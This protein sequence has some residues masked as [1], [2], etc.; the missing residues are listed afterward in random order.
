MGLGKTIQMISLIMADREA[1]Q[2]KQ[3]ASGAS[4]ILAPLSVMSNWSQQIERHVKPEHA[5]RV[6]TYHGGKR[7]KLDLKTIVN[8]D[9]VITTYETMMAEFFSSTKAV[10]R[11]DGLFSVT[12]RRLIMDE[13]HTI[14]NPRTKK[15]AAACSLLAQSRWVLTGTP[16]INTLKDLFSLVKFLRLSGGLDKYEI[17]NAALIRPI[18]QGSEQGGQLLQTL[19]RDICLRR[20][21]DMRFIDLKLPELSEYV[22]RI[23]FLEHE[24]EKYKSL[25]AEAQG[26]LVKYRAQQATVGVNAAKEYRFL[27]EILL[28]MRQVCNHWKLCGEG[29]I[30]A[31]SAMGDQVML[32]LTPEN[33]RLLQEMLQ[34]TIDA[35]DDC[36]V[37]M[38]SMSNDPVI[39]VCTHAYCYPCIERVIETQHK[40]PMCRSELK[41]VDQLVRPAAEAN[42][43]LDIDENESSSKIETLLQILGASRN[44]DPT[45]KTVIFSQWTTFID[46]VQVQLAKHGFKFVRIDGSM[47][48]HA[49]DASVAALENDPE[50]TILLASLAVCSVGLN[51][52]AANQA[53]LADTW[54]APAIEQQA[55]DRIH[56][57]GQK[58]E[59][60]VFRLVMNGSIEEEVLKIQEEKMKL[61]TLA[62]AEKAGG[63]KGKKGTTSTIAQIER[64]LGGGK[65]ATAAQQET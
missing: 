49:R 16:I 8:Y 4:L 44:K 59:T 54:W 47:P 43:Q 50:C 3:G 1:S 42:T 21:K 48:P 61:M 28:R 6:L 62:F 14:R 32:D 2:Q 7:E 9:V 24:Q 57:L 40:C 63:K 51:L 58:K 12:W 55:I 64:L 17:F 45:T 10:P 25:V 22:H 31:L 11:A 15:A 29:R 26:T 13:G 34:L 53:I 38:E 33:K 41:S 36:P 37:C 20:K 23:D 35:Q 18:N 46:V 56:R 5:L 65:G 30:K 60:T 52:V 39:T 19:I 27:L